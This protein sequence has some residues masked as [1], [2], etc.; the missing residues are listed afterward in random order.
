MQFQG[1]NE[2]PHAYSTRIRDGTDVVDIE[3]F[4]QAYLVTK[5]R[6]LANK[7]KENSIQTLNRTI[8]TNNKAITSGM[9]INPD[10]QYCG[11]VE[12]MEHMYY[13]CENFVEKQ[14]LDLSGYLTTLARVKYKTQLLI[15]LTFKSI[16]FNWEAPNARSSN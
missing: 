6:H 5:N 15:F 14:W 2:N 7:T 10:C 3:N 1:R 11:E 16:I 8:W 9:R 12:T 13:G 4:K